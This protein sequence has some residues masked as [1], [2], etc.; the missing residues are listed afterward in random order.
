MTAQ[1]PSSAAIFAGLRDQLFQRDLAALAPIP[2]DPTFASAPEVFGVAMEAGL[3]AGSYLVFGLRDGSAS[4]YFS[5]GGGSIGGQGQPQ[6]NAAAKELVKIAV[7][8]V[9]KLPLVD[10]YPVPSVGRVR[11]SIFTPEGV[12]ASEANQSELTSPQSNLFPLFAAA[13]ELITG[14]RLLEQREPANESTYL[15]CLLTALARGKATSVTIGDGEPLANP[16]RL[17]TDGLDLKWIDGFGFEFEKLSGAQV[18]QSL[19]Q[20]AGFRWFH[21]WKTESRFNVRLAAHG[22]ESFTDV[23]FSVRRRRDGGRD[24]VEI[25]VLRPG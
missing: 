2:N 21:F 8:L 6:I 7:T 9:G 5:S 3:T 15:N 13:Q 20:M 10:E 18:L 23:T 11:F 14:F 19:L 22:G 16:S 4:L 25:S 12:R 1:P 17:T 24:Q